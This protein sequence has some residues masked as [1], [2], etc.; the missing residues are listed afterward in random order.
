MKTR[1]EAGRDDVCVLRLEQLYPF[2]TTP[3]ADDLSRF[4]NAEVIWCQEEP[5]NMG[6]WLYAAPWIEEVMGELNMPAGRPKY[7]GRPAAASPATGLFS[8]H[9]AEQKKL[10][11]QALGDPA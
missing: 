10:I 7:A 6:S 9:V 1:D 3:L 2:P 4:P 8:R 11:A 5:K